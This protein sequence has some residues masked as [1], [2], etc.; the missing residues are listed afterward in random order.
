LSNYDIPSHSV[1]LLSSATFL[2]SDFLAEDMPRTNR[3]SMSVHEKSIEERIV[4]YILD[5]LAFTLRCVLCMSLK[6]D[7]QNCLV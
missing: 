3:S 4:R 1:L 5:T 6:R 7:V 2:L